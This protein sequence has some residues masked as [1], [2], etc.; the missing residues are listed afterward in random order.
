MNL[1]YEALN[2]APSIYEQDGVTMTKVARSELG[3]V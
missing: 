3:V 2:V 1:E